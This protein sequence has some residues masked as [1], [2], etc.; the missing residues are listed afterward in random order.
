MDL[1]KSMARLRLQKYIAE[2]GVA[3]RRACEKLI[4]EGR[5]RVNG[6]PA[7]RLGTTVDPEHDRI[8]VDGRRLEREEK[9]YVALNKPPGYIC[10]SSDPEKRPTVFD[11]LRQ[12]KSFPHRLRLFSIGRLDCNSE[13]LLLLTNDGEFAHL[14]AHP[15]H[16][17]EKIYRA[18]IDG[19]LTPE[20]ISQLKKGVKSESELLTLKSICLHGRRGSSS[21]YEVVLSEGRNRQV[22]RMFEALGIKINR[23]QRVSV[24][25]LTLRALNLGEWRYLRKDEV[26]SLVNLASRE[27]FSPHKQRR[28]AANRS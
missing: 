17:V 15:R 20:N 28:A 1:R 9:C 6:Q 22:R 11:L 24:G 27:G 18:W 21:C 3:S 16:V 13:G 19:S 23:L 14:L 7:T 10:S 26:L 2:C 25:T 5:V 12:D 8:E 4:V